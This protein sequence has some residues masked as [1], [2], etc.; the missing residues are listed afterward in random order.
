MSF[1]ADSGMLELCCGYMSH[2]A[3]AEAGSLSRVPPEFFQVLQRAWLKT[4]C[5]D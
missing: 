1:L 5:Q 4:R 2:I 3:W